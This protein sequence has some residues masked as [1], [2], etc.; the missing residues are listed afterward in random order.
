M[1]SILLSTI[2]AASFGA[3]ATTA[4]TTTGQRIDTLEMAIGYSMVEIGVAQQ[5]LEEV[6]QR[7]THHIAELQR[8]KTEVKKDA[9]S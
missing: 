4:Q 9:Q 7:L 6:Q 3:A 2:L 8:L 1:K 5:K